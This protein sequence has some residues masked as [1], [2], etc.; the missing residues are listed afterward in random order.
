M[1]TPSFAEEN[2]NK[3]IEAKKIDESA[4]TVTPHMAALSCVYVFTFFF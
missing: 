1:D 4:A 2:R 3:P